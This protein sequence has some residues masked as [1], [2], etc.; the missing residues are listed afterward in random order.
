MK[1]V[2]TEEYPLAAI[3]VVC[4][5]TWLGSYEEMAVVN[6]LSGSSLLCP[7]YSNFRYVCIVI[8]HLTQEN[9]CLS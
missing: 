4:F 3:A 2:N 5:S 7:P 8:F 6:C 9:P 1:S